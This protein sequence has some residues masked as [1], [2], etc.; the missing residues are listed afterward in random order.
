MS[1]RLPTLNQL[2]KA[3]DVVHSVIKATPQYTWPLLNEALGAEVWL[4]HENHTPVGSFKVRGGIVFFQHL[5]Q[6]GSKPSGVISAT[7]G[8]HGQSVAFAARRHHIPVTIV[9]PH[10]NSREKN[11]AMR[12]LGATL[13]EH[14]EDFQEARE[15]ADQIAEQRGLLFVPS[16]HPFLVHGVASWSLEL[17]HSVDDLDTVYVPI[18]LGSGISGMVAVREALGRKTEIVGVVSTDAPAYAR[19][20]EYREPVERPVRTQ[21]ADGLACRVPEPAALEIILQHVAR[22]VEVTDD[23]VAD[24]MRLI[25]TSTH[26]VA[27][28]AGAAGVAAMLKERSRI[29]GRRVGTVLGGG[30]VDR[31]V[32]AKILHG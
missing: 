7:R 15:H 20:F 5:A 18:G 4:K 17:L 25:F 24:A 28:G 19:S 3:A 2:E 10:G 12:A 23:D 29:A 26:N 21:L 8:N 9:V 27:E 14:G 16:Y 11:A 22:I 32:F 13:I 6:S 1:V 30:N 31:E